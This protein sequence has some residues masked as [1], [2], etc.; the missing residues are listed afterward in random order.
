REEA[1]L[2]L[3]GAALR[4]VP[5]PAG[6]GCARDLPGLDRVPGP[7]AGDAPGRGAGRGR[8]RDPDAAVH[9][10]VDHRSV[11]TS[12]AAGPQNSRATASKTSAHVAT[13]ARSTH[14]VVACDP[15]PAGPKTTVG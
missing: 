8:I 6:R 15:A 14:S 4:H 10:D 3:L 7:R 13:D 2:R 5:L 11:G 9:M 12:A 1:E